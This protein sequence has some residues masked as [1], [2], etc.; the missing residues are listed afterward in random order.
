MRK[1]GFLVLDDVHAAWEEIREV[2]LKV[3]SLGLEP[4][5]TDGRVGICRLVSEFNGAGAIRAEGG[6]G[7]TAPS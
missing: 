6:G 7:G 3:S 5:G 2:F 1:G 4:A